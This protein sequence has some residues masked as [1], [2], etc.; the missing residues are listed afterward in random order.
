MYCV[1]RYPVAGL[2]VYCLHSDYYRLKY[3]RATVKLSYKPKILIIFFMIQPKHLLWVHQRTISVSLRRF[4][5]V[6]AIN[7]LVE[8]QRNNKKI[9]SVISGSGR[10]VIYEKQFY[11]KLVI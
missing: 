10:N 6:P 9:L 3:S 7:I 2:G 1:P 5:R 11:L 8:N 4:F